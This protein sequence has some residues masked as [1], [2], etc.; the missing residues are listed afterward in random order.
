M[1]KVV[2]SIVSAGILL[3]CSSL[4]TDDLKNRYPLAAVTTPEQQGDIVTGLPP[5]VWHGLDKIN[6]SAS[7]RAFKEYIEEGLPVNTPDVHGIPALGHAAATGDIEYLN[8]LFDEDAEPHY[9]AADNRPTPGNSCVFA[10]LDL[11]PTG[12]AAAHG[13]TEAVRLLL[14]HGAKPLGVQNA[15]VH[16]HLDILKLLH[17]A[18]ANLHEGEYE[19]DGIFYPNTCHA[20]SDAMLVYLIENGVSKEIPAENIREICCNE[21]DM[22]KY[23]AMYVRNQIWTEEQAKD[24][25]KKYGF[26]FKPIK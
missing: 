11:S 26:L 20:K 18:G 14:A 17:E 9:P 24:F 15:I 16:D 5:S 4:S 13:R 2:L 7:L 25:R 10:G 1:F 19:T 8:Y 23:L 3:S 12:L 21:V 6:H 22:E